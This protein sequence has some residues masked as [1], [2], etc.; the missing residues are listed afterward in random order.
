AAVCAL[1]AS[2]IGARIFARVGS[3]WSLGDDGDGIDTDVR[4]ASIV[5]GGDH[6]S[7]DLGPVPVPVGTLE[8]AVK[9]GARIE[10]ERA[11][12][13][14]GQGDDRD[15]GQA[16]VAGA[17]GAAAVGALEDAVAVN[18]HVHGGRRLGVDGQSLDGMASV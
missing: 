18:T 3:G 7:V 16:G 2:S 4:V 15:V 9:P 12:G 6:A 13:V 8:D 14:D 1:G 17:P 11:P 5:V 10:G